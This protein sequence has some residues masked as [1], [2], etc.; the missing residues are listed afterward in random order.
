MINGYQELF[1]DRQKF[2]HHDSSPGNSFSFI[3]IFFLFPRFI[4]LLINP[5]DILLRHDLMRFE[6]ATISGF[7]LCESRHRPGPGYKKKV[8]DTSL[9]DSPSLSTPTSFVYTLHLALGRSSFCCH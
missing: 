8:L 7:V 9:M 5:L 4:P 1:H 2:G 3:F 6:L